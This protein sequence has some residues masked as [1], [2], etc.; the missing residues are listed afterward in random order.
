MVAVQVMGNDVAVATAA[1]QGNFEL[2][3]FMPVAAYNFLQSARL[4]RRSQLFRSI[5]TVLS[6]SPQTKKRC[7]ITCITRLCSLRRSILISDMK[8][9]QRPPRKRIK[10]NI[11]LKEACVA[12]RLFDRRKV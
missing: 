3:V 11:S 10:D 8:T 2:N 1:S 9:R 5:R 7:I 4:A 12:A 6:E